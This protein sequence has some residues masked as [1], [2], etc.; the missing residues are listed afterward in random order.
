MNT[1]TYTH[2]NA[3][4]HPLTYPPYTHQEQ[5][6]IKHSCPLLSAHT[7]RRHDCVCKSLL[8]MSSPHCCECASPHTHIELSRPWEMQNMPKAVWRSCSSW[9]LHYSNLQVNSCVRHTFIFQAIWGFSQQYGESEKQV[10]HRQLLL[11]FYTACSVSEGRNI[12]TYLS[13]SSQWSC[14]YRDGWNKWATSTTLLLRFTEKTKLFLASRLSSGLKW[15]I[16]LLC[17]QQQL[18]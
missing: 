14:A 1:H 15:I 6:R 18:K 7:S 11:L 13:Q 10:K 16:L 9:P 12:A 5:N 17:Y 3:T 4:T 8:W 2:T